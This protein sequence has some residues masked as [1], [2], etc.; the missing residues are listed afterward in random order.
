MNSSMKFTV[1]FQE[2]LLSLLDSADPTQDSDAEICEKWFK[3]LRKDPL[4]RSRLENVHSARGFKYGFAHFGSKHWFKEKDNLAKK[5][6]IQADRRKFR[7][8]L[9]ADV[10]FINQLNI[11]DLEDMVQNGDSGGLSLL[12]M[13]EPVLPAVMFKFLENT[14]PIKILELVN[15]RKAADINSLI[16]K[17]SSLAHFC[18]SMAD[19][20]AHD[21]ALEPALAVVCEVCGIMKMSVQ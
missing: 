7:I 9:K 15:K 8:G 16:Q 4:A 6:K 10:D 2:K 17:I 20:F 5:L 12:K 13:Q 11:M 21:E 19:Y 14:P 1:Q 18:Q 3:K